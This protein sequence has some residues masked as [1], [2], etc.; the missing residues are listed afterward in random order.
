MVNVYTNGARQIDMGTVGNISYRLD[1]SKY[2]AT[3]ED[4]L[5]TA[6]AELNKSSTKADIKHIL[7]RSNQLRENRNLPHYIEDDTLDRVA[8]IRSMEMAYS[9]YYSH[10]RP[11]GSCLG[12]TK[13]STV[14]TA[15]ATNPKTSYKA[16]ENITYGSDWEVAIGA[17]ENS[18]SHLSAILSSEYRY[19]GIGRYTFGGRTYWTQIFMS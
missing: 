1:A 9:G 14:Y 18:S 10:K 6:I 5:S 11:N 4:L 7:D 12:G 15:I 2:K 8:M 17:W 16:G 19:I 3:S 13:F